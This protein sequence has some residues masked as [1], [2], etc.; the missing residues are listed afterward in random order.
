M[1]IDKL[2]LLRSIELLGST[3]EV[4]SE[5]RIII[6][7]ELSNVIDKSA[8]RAKIRLSKSNLFNLIVSQPSLLLALSPFEIRCLSCKKVISYPAWHY[9]MKF[10]R[11]E[12]HYFVCFSETSPHQVK[13]DC[14]R[15]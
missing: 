9:T 8:G 1:D 12:F 15:R 14:K 11:N 10:D 5:K 6:N 13:L 4:E 3:S 7:G 2:S